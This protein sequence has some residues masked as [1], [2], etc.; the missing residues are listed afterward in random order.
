M[1]TLKQIYIELRN[2]VG[3]TLVIA[4]C[5]IAAKLLVIQYHKLYEPE[6]HT[7]SVYG[8]FSDTSIP[9]PPQHQDVLSSSAY[10]GNDESEL[11]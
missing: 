3:V 1:T 2:L 5:F 9:L 8:S 10:A 6:N 11:E 7:K 4:V